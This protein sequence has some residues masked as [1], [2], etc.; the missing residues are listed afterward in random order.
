[1]LIKET[2]GK[3]RKQKG[4]VGVEGSRAANASLVRN[5]PT[6]SRSS[7][8]ADF[9]HIMLS[10]IIVRPRYKKNKSFCIDSFKRRNVEK[11]ANE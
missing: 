10:G 9:L 4:S 5:R 1:M 7:V 3:D 11:V 8:A 6:C 2:G